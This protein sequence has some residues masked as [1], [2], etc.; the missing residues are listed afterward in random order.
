MPAGKL[1]RGVASDGALTVGPALAAPEPHRPTGHPAVQ[2][3]LESPWSPV[4]F[5]VPPQ[6]GKIRFHDLDLPD[7][8]LHAVADQKFSYCTPIQSQILPA[9]LAGRDAGGRAQ[10]G[11]GKTAAFLIG[12]FTRLLRHPLTT[13]SRNGMPRALVLAPTRELALQIFK[14][15][16][17]LGKYCRFR[18]LV[19]FGGMDYKKQQDQLRS[20]N[21][22]LVV[23]TPGRL[24]DFRS[25]GLL[26]LGRVEVLVLDEADRMLD[27]GFIPDVKRIIYSLPPR[28]R[29][30][31]M[32]FSATLSQDILRL[33]SRWMKDPLLV[34]VEPEQVTVLAT[35][36]RVFAVSAR[37]KFALLFNLLQHEPMKRVLV[38]RNR[39]DGVDR[40]ARRLAL[41]G[42]PCAQLSGEVPQE[43]RIRIL[44]DFRAGRIRV[45]IATDV[46]GRGIHVEAISHV[47]NYDIPEEAEDYVHRIGR[48]GRAGA[49]GIAITFACEEGAFVLP[50]IE[51]FIGRPLP[52]IQPEDTYLQIP[53]A[54]AQKVATAGSRRPAY[55]PPRSRPGGSRGRRYQ[56]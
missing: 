22:D 26:N 54:I 40:L 36:Q 34:E 30:Q 33:A 5:H 46:A 17:C 9:L 53:D 41:A 2:S 47:V 25:S 29:R 52:C 28:E 14:D 27:M 55:R 32:L 19:I 15:A 56:R 24:L 8:I 6:A 4:R 10:T 48:T 35:D 42:I 38:F 21:I 3:D 12:I 51:K 31:T 16:Q 43:K 45:V 20:P 1:R 11:T 13:P 39:R 44:E 23:A 37:K 49:T 50:A 7:P 18:N